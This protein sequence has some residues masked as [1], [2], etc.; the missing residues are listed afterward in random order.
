MTNL[1]R[2]FLMVLGV[3]LLA[4]C[5]RHGGNTVPAVIATATPVP[6][7]EFI[8]NNQTG[9]QLDIT[10]TLAKSVLKPPPKN[11]T[12]A[13]GKNAFLMLNPKVIGPGA[14]ATVGITD[15][16]KTRSAENQLSISS[17]L[18][19]QLQKT[20]LMLMFEVVSTVVTGGDQTIIAT[21]YCRPNSPC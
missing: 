16:A 2:G 20:K 4:E 8:I 6:Q 14:L 17:T 15:T 3:V 7:Y 21:M 19:L 5:T 9:I 10:T 13:P 1:V 12:L 18:D 11:M